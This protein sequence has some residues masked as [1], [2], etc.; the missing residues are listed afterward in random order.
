RNAL[1]SYAAERRAEAAD[2]LMQEVEKVQPARQVRPFFRILVCDYPVQG[3]SQPED[4][5]APQ[6]ATVTFWAPRGLEPK[7]FCEGQ[8][9]L[10]SGL[11]VSPQRAVAVS[12]EPRQQQQQQ[13]IKTP[14]RLNFNASGSSW[15]PMSAEQ[16]AI[17]LSEFRERG[18]LHID[19]LW[20][21]DS[22][23]EVDLVG[24]V[25]SCRHPGAGQDDG[26]VLTR[27]VLRLESADEHGHKHYAAISFNAET[28]GSINPEAGSPVT[29]RNCICL[30]PSNAETCTFLLRAD[31]TTEFVFGVPSSTGT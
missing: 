24:S 8:R 17:D 3:A 26:M 9:Y 20:Q 13:Q 31:D 18:V 4:S 23:Q 15:R 19:E 10:L 27:S 25:H 7:D 30:K 11:T 16:S 29:V 6:L 22:D 5:S 1:E 12:D 14:L 2:T 28:F 21:V